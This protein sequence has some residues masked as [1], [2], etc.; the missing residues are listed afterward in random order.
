MV[1]NLSPPSPVSPTV[2]FEANGKQHGVLKLP[3][4]RDD[5]AWGAIHIP[6]CVVKNGQGPT[7]LFFGGNDGD[8]YEGPI[9]LYELARTLRTDEI[10]GRVIIVPALN[11][12]AFRAAKRTSPI[13]GGNMNRIFP[14]KPDGSITEKIADFVERGL[15]PRADL[16]L[17]IHS[18]G[19]SLDF[20]PFAAAHF[21][22]DKAQ[23]ARS[24][25]A[26]EAFGAPY[27]VRMREIDAVGMLDTA[28]ENLG[29]TFVTTELA[30]G[31]T[32]TPGSAGVAKRGVRNLL[33][34][35]GILDGPPDPSKT[36]WL[37]MEEGGTFAESPTDGLIDYVVSLG[38]EVRAG[39]SVAHITPHGRTGAEPVTVTAPG[40]GLLIGRHF[41]GLVQT[42]DCVAVVGSLDKE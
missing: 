25:N 31:G 6:I 36:Q 33:K 37:T 39:A 28:A 18:G 41:P 34:H 29:K 17:D 16:V 26:A 22:E 40:D 11:Y 10:S 27:T 20:V 3:W 15:L 12:P 24:M 9:A 35:A 1:P 38:D 42:G 19:R 13:D 23:E 14:G 2:D 4:S 32:A 5:S 21:L 8:E 30:G 7:A